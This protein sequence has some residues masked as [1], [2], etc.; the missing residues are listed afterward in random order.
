MKRFLLFTFVFC[1][2][3]IGFAKEFGSQKDGFF[4]QMPDDWQ[5][6]RLLSSFVGTAIDRKDGAIGTKLTAYKG[7]LTKQPLVLNLIT[8]ET[9]DSLDFNRKAVIDGLSKDSQMRGGIQNTTVNLN[10]KQAARLE[11]VRKSGHRLIQYLL[12]DRGRLWSIL[13]V[14]PQNM[15]APTK[16]ELGQIANS[17]R[18]A[19]PEKKDQ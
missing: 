7:V 5:T 10:G 16:A 4:I 3:A 12:V 6:N 8:F 17:F 18:L 19:E 15:T 11:Y 1:L 2:A 9:E 14:G 13:F